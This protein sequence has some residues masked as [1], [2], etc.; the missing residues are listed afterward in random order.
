MGSQKQHLIKKNIIKLPKEYENDI[1]EQHRASRPH[2]VNPSPQKMSSSDK[3]NAF[4]R[5]H[6]NESPE[7]KQQSFMLVSSEQ[8]DDD[9][10]NEEDAM[11]HLEQK[12]DEC[13]D[14]VF[15]GDANCKLF[16]ILNGVL[17]IGYD[18]NSTKR[19]PPHLCMTFDTLLALAN[20]QNG[21]V[22][23]KQSLMEWYDKHSAN[24]LI[25]S[26]EEDQILNHVST[27][28]LFDEIKPTKEEKATIE[29]KKDD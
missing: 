23:T 5:D 8:F 20:Y 7:Y 12:E 6:M 26:E 24:K 11:N 16:Q 25:Y 4:L 19:L 9:N 28:T 13:C 10:D 3:Q 21:Q 22:L 2:S 15:V 17:V 29:C 14:D 1:F 18:S 27:Q